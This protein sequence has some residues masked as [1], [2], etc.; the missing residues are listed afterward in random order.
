MSRRNGELAMLSV[1][2]TP[3]RAINRRPL[4]V[5]AGLIVSALAAGCASSSHDQLTVGTVP[6]DY[7][8]R[9]PIVVAESQV[10]EAIPVTANT[11]SLSLRHRNVVIDFANR[12]RRSSS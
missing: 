4:T 10:V 11:R 1:T 12:F 2:D 6:D 5:A 8:T 7:R 3:R 9:H